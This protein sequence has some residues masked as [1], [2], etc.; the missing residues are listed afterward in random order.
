M[1]QENLMLLPKPNR[2]TTSSQ[3]ANTY[4]IKVWED[5][6]EPSE[7]QEELDVIGNC[8]EMDTVVLDICTHGGSAD[9]AALFNRALRSCA[10]NTVGIIGPA[11][12]SA[13]SI[14]A[15]SCAEWILDDT[16][17]LMCHTSTYGMLAKDTDIFEHANFA[18]KSLRNLFESVYSGFLSP[19]ELED[20]IKGTPFYFDADQLAE[21]LDRLTD[22][23][24][25][26]SEKGCDDPNCTSCG[27]INDEEP[28]SLEDMMADAVEKGVDAAMKKIAKKY[29]LVVK[30][31][32]EKKP[33]PRKAKVTQEAQIPVDKPSEEG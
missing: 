22:Y 24:M 4:F 2:I 29:D 23:R 8:N 31:P 1:N 6:G 17:Q 19:D 30:N 33:T 3:T 14:I 16:S 5:I 26:Q 9:T 21:R 12:S 15:L 13:G 25:E 18:R 27:E 10:G 11:C 20:V 28:F 32:P 7:W